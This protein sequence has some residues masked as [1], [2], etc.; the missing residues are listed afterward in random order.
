MYIFLNSKDI[1]SHI[2][3]QFPQPSQ[4]F[5]LSH[6][7]HRKKL[8]TVWCRSP[9]PNCETFCHR[10]SCRRHHLLFCRKRLKIHLFYCSFP[11]LLYCPRCEFVSVNTNCSFC[12]LIYLKQTYR[13]MKP[14]LILLDGLDLVEYVLLGTSAAQQWQELK[15]SFNNLHTCTHMSKHGNL[16]FLQSNHYQKM[17]NCNLMHQTTT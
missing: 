12:R 6:W 17:T 5:T 15:H 3:L 2:G 7:L 9:L 14:K 16:T 13:V 8:E 1:N 10:T 11:N 4:I